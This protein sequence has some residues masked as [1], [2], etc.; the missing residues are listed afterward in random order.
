VFFYE[1]QC[2][3]RPDA[4]DGLQVVAAKEKTEINELGGKGALVYGN[5]GGEHKKKV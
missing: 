2:R 1:F 4:F 3:F 5:I